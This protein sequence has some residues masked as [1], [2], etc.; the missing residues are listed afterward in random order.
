MSEISLPARRAQGVPPEDGSRS[1]AL[2]ELRAGWSGWEQEFP[3]LLLERDG[4]GW[5][6]KLIKAKDAVQEV[7]YSR[8]GG[9][10]YL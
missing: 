8:Q 5:R 7:R 1:T 9:L 4:A 6:G 2:A 10:V 3:V